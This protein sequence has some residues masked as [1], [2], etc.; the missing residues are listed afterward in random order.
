MAHCFQ[1]PLIHAELFKTL[2]VNSIPLQQDDWDNLAWDG[3]EF[4]QTGGVSSEVGTFED[5]KQACEANPNC[6]QY[7]HHGNVCQI[8]MSV[9]L[10]HKKEAD[11]EGVW[12]S[13]WHK[14]R[15]AD[16]ISKQPACDE[17]EFPIQDA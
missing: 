2:L 4:G 13:G 7:L 6:F 8:G 11:S 16:W 14:T 1:G 17:V 3:G 9:R 5:C 15:L 12:R 10:G